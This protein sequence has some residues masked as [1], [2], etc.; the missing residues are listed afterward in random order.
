[1][2]IETLVVCMSCIIMVLISYLYVCEMNILINKNVRE[3]SLVSITSFVAN[4][5]KTQQGYENILKSLDE[6]SITGY[7]ILI[8]NTEN[9]TSIE[10]DGSERGLTPEERENLNKT[11]IDSKTRGVGSITRRTGLC[12]GKL[13]TI[14]S[15]IQFTQMNDNIAV[16]VST[17]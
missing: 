10:D 4:M 9:Y 12:F 16:L 2:V 6:N 15:T 3:E 13:N 14:S 11:L 17:C 8:V 1:M 5:C 7:T